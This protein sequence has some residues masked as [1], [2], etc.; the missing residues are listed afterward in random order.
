MAASAQRTID[1]WPVSA[2]IIK[3]I[4]RSLGEK[5]TDQVRGRAVARLEALMRENAREPEAVRAHTFGSIYPSI[6]LYEALRTIMSREAAED[7]FRKQFHAITAKSAPVL[8]AIL[9]LPGLHRRMPRFACR[10]LV[11][12]YG[13]EAGFAYDILRDDAEAMQVDMLRCPYHEACGRYG[14]P[15]ITSVFCEADD[16]V[17]GGM[18]PKLLWGRT[19]TLGKGDDRCDFNISIKP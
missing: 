10:M 6:A 5:Q 19:K 2:R 16:I 13:T 18:H 17:Y 15:E 7:Y 12:R 4:R 9:R 14:C 11:T 1:R 8:R 3:E